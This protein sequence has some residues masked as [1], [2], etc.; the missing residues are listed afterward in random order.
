MDTFKKLLKTR[1]IGVF[2]FSILA[3]IFLGSLPGFQK[4]IDALTYTDYINDPA[5][6]HYTEDYE[7]FEEFR[8]YDEQ[9][10]YDTLSGEKL[11]RRQIAVGLFVTA[12][13]FA[14]LGVYDVYKDDKLTKEAEKARLAKLKG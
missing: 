9:E 5:E 10:T 1:F 8:V 6:D 13:L 4:Q 14:L 12:G 2:I 7:D 3:L 11:M